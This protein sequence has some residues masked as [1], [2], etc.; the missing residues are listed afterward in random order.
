MIQDPTLGRSPDQAKATKLHSRRLFEMGKDESPSAARRKALRDADTLSFS[1]NPSRPV[2]FYLDLTKR[3]L[4][5]FNIAMDE[6]RLDDAYVFGVRFASFCLEGLPK[7]PSYNKT[8]MRTVHARQVE[9]VLAGVEDV[10]ARMDA[11][12][13]AKR[14]QQAKEKEEQEAKQQ[15]ARQENIEKSAMAKL[16]AL[17]RTTSKRDT[18]SGVSTAAANTAHQK[19]TST[20]AKHIKTSL[21]SALDS[22]PSLQNFSESSTATQEATSSS[23]FS[24]G[25]R[26]DEQRTIELLERTIRHQTDRLPHLEAAMEQLRAH[27]KEALRQEQRQVAVGKMA[28]RK[29]LQKTLTACKSSIFAMETQIMR[30]EAAASDRDANLA[31]KKA[32][33][34]MK[35]LQQVG[36]DQVDMVHDE[37]SELQTVNDALSQTVLDDLDEDALLSELMDEE[38]IPAEDLPENDLLQLPSVPNTPTQQDEAPE[39][40]PLMATIA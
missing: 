26:P 30:I 13:L 4:A 2:A 17:Q 33:L 24:D 6:R 15:E 28:Q 5:N 14:R 21:P 8:S 40:E 31:M 38:E 16:M 10:T 7:H 35:E 18:T 27:A 22:L 37:L 1:I 3:L 34:M 39:K 25:L 36:G 9:A 32:S 20:K 29:R 23:N 12:E 19:T 11:E